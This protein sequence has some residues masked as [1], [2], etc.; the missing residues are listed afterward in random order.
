MDVKT[1]Y[2]NPKFAA[3]FTGRNTFSAA[4]RKEYKKLKYKKIKKSLEAVDPY[5]LHKRVQRPLVYRR[6]YAKRI[7]EM[8]QMDLVDMG[9]KYLT[10]NDNF[11]YILTTID[12]LSKKAH[13]FKMKSKNAT[14]MNKVMKLFLGKVK[15]IKF[16]ASDSGTEFLS[17]QNLDLLKRNK[18]KH[19]N[20]TGRNKAAIVERF[21]RTLKQ[22]MWRYF[23]STGN[24]RWVDVLDD[25]VNGYNNTKHRSIGM[26]PNEVTKNNEQKVRLKLYPPI[27]KK[28]QY[29]LPVYNIGDTV[30][31]YSKKGA[32]EKSYE[33]NMSYHVYTI[34][35][36]IRSYP[37][38]YKLK[39]FNDKILN[40]S[41]YQSELQKVDKSDG[42][43]PVNKIIKTK[44][45]AGRIQY[46]VNFLGYP[47]DFTNW[48]PAQN[49]FTV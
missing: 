10:E 18:I 27:H 41:F 44:R 43:W 28:P 22:R 14:E 20:L 13:A 15:N 30:R 34:S 1:A 16:I 12:V 23:T 40:K 37:I 46:L 21:N 29:A 7:N 32:F 9:T 49:L 17:K 5:T 8:I 2:R 42:I 48:I 31:I 11:R 26:A 33:L 39:D 45:V 47:D 25:L 38:T 36:I 19:F 4:F 3:A 35:K 6:T 24:W